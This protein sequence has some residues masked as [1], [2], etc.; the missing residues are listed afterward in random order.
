MV[1]FSPK[2]RGHIL[3]MCLKMN[4][5]K[6]REMMKFLIKFLENEKKNPYSSTIYREY[7]EN[8]H[9]GLISQNLPWT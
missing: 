9:S 7:R 8:V 6:A 5:Q 4:Q 1:V 3:D 2:A